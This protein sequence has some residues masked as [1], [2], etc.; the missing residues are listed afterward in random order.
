MNTGDT[1][2]ATSLLNNICRLPHTC[3]V[4]VNVDSMFVQITTV[5]SAL[6]LNEKGRG[7]NVE[8][9]HS[10]PAPAPIKYIH[11]YSKAD[12]SRPEVSRQMYEEVSSAPV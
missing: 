5:T 1:V 11:M 9:T 8:M 3:Q 2:R 12:C 10:S 7:Q 6:C 4:S